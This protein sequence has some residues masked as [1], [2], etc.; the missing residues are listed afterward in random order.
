MTEMVTEAETEAEAATE[1]ATEL[2][3]EACL[4]SRLSACWRSAFVFVVFAVGSPE[5]AC[6]WQEQEREKEQCLSAPSTER[7]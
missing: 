6:L 3:T 2:G 5:P 7:G 4:R 1:A